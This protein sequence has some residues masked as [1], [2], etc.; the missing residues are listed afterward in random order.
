MKNFPDLS[1]IEVTVLPVKLD[2][3]GLEEFAGVD[4][5]LSVW[6]AVRLRC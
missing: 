4:C 5:A 3:V 1:H 6:K 2:R